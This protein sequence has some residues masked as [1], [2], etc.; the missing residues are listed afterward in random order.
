MIGVSGC[1]V[2]CRLGWLILAASAAPVAGAAQTSEPAAVMAPLPAAAQSALDKGLAAARQQEWL[3]AIRY[4][5][6]ARSAAPG[7]AVPLYNLGLAEAQLPGRELRAVAWFDAY[8]ALDP[9]AANAAAVRKEASDLEIRAEGE[10]AKLIEALKSLASQMPPP[11]YY[12]PPGVAALLTKSGDAEAAEQFAQS[13]T[14]DDMRTFA[15]QGIVEALV[16]LNRIADAIKRADLLPDG[17]RQTAFDAIFNAQL[18]AGAYADAKAFAQRRPENYQLDE[19]LSLA[20]AA[21]KVGAHD[22]VTSILSD[23]RALIDKVSDPDVRENQLASFAVTEYQTG[24]RD[25]AETLLGQVRNYA[26][27]YSGKDK[28]GHKMYVLVGLSRSENR[29][30]RRSEALGLMG[31]ALAARDAAK[32]AHEEQMG[33]TGNA[34]W[35]WTGTLYGLRDYDGARALLTH[36]YGD[37]PAFQR[38]LVDEIATEKAS[39]LADACQAVKGAS[40]KTLADVGSSPAQRAQAWAAYIKGCLGGP[41]FTTDFRST[42]AGIGGFNP[43]YEPKAQAIFEHTRQPAD[44]LA[45][46]I[47]DIAQLEHR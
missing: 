31:E 12:G 5:D 14:N 27:N 38:R 11:D 9:N 22:D 26:E 3:V 8:L 33:I 1:R 43:Q 7:S 39:A 2:L 35:I 10:V 42:M 18:A 20:E 21:Y 46:A 36:L 45:G 19:H 15:G 29:M 28:N 41:L 17:Y 40:L 24:R 25:D 47:I 32:Q 13:Q 44:D 16:R 4:F 23:A 34:F 6:V 37:D 30:D